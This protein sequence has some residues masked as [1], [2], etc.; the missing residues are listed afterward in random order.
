MQEQKPKEQ[1]LLL[2]AVCTCVW[3]V[4]TPYTCVCVCTHVYMLEHSPY[5]QTYIHIYSQEHL[6]V[7]TY[8]VNM[9]TLNTYV[10]ILCV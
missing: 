9:H 2:A 6:H 3:K 7:C 5:P 1:H 8:T 4:F 10:Y